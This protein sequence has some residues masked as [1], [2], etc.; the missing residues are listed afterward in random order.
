MKIWKI[1]C[2]VM[3]ALRIPRTVH[4][5]DRILSLIRDELTRYTWCS[6]QAC[7]CMGCVN[8]SE[9]QTIG[10]YRL[11]LPE[12]I[13]WKRYQMSEVWLEFRERRLQRKRS[14]FLWLL[15][16]RPVKQNVVRLYPPI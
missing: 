4:Q 8:R 12:W 5:V 7:G 13:R 6:S 16:S 14:E 15:L 3:G 1:V 10:M 9:I 11:R 2:V